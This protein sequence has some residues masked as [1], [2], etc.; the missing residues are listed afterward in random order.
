MNSIAFIAEQKIQ[1]AMKKG[2]LTVE[3]WKNRPLPMEDDSLV[4]DDL[5]MAYK[6]LKNS[7]YLPPEIEERKEVK[8]LEELIAATED[9]H[10]R[11]KQMKKLSV[12]LMKID[13][14]RGK[15]SNITQQDDYYR[16]VV[17]KISLNA[18]PSSSSK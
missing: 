12:L 1:E 6:I 11:L 16:M 15:T 10:V 3:R 5:K 8:R 14:R 9:E 4:P 17:E 2:D 18:K 13:A 7:G